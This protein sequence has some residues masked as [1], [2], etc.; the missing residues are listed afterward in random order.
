MQCYASKDVPR[1]EKFCTS[2][3][4]PI[5]E[6][7]TFLECFE[8]IPLF[9]F[10]YCKVKYGDSPDDKMDCFRNKAGL[11]LDQA[12]CDDPLPL[13][14]VAD[15]KRVFLERHTCYREIQL[16]GYEK[17]GLEYCEYANLADSGAKYQCIE[18]LNLI[19]SLDGIPEECKQEG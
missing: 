5:I 1:G 8:G 11:T 12:Y 13:E 4:D 14:D 19:S 15:G 2:N 16:P 3:F 17:K 7:D 9:T 10:G 6:R 18:D